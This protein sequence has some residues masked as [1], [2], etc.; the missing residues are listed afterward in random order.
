MTQTTCH[1]SLT[2]F[3]LFTF[4]FTPVSSAVTPSQ[5]KLHFF[6]TKIRPLL[7]KHCYK[8]H[9]KT[10]EKIKGN[11]TLDTKMGWTMGGDMGPAIKPGDPNRSLILKAVSYKDPDLQMPPKKKL[12]NRAIQLLRKWIADG[13]IDPRAG[14]PHVTSNN[15]DIPAAKKTW[16]YTTPKSQPLPKTQNTNW[17]KNRIDHFILAKLES[18]S[19]RPSQPAS[20]T[21]LIRRLYFDLIGLPPTTQQLNQALNDQSPTWIQTLTNKLLATKAYG[22]RWA[23]FWLDLARYAEDQAHIVGSNSSLFYPNA[24]LYRDWV[25]NALNADTP[26]NRFIQLQLAADIIQPDDLKSHV[27]LGFM[28]LGPKYYRRNAPDVMA[29]EWEDRVDTLS[30]GLLGLTV[31]CA[32]C[33]DH[34]YDPIS[35][36]DYY[37]LAGVF[38]STQMYNRKLNAQGNTKSPKDALHII[39]EGKPRDLNVLIRG[40]VQNKGPIVKRRFLE[41]LSNPTSKPFTKGSGRLELA[42]AITSPQ[43]PL[44]ARVI[45]NRIWATYFHQGIVA[46]PSNFGSLGKKPSH[47]QL[48]DDLAARFIKNGWSLKWL[49]R[50]ITSSAT[51]RQSSTPSTAAYT[52]DPANTLLSHVPRRRMSVEQWRDNILLLAGRLDIN[53]TGKSIDPRDPK[54]TKRTVYAKVSRL[55]LNPMLVTFDFPDPNAHAATRVQTVTPLQKLFV[56]NSPFIIAQARALADLTAKQPDNTPAKIDWLYTRLFS[57]KPTPPEKQL[58]TQYLQNTSGQNADRWLKYTQALLA[59]N[60]LFFID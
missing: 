46:T 57:R 30:R 12:S 7:T 17:P 27:A 19:L 56:L 6:E 21:T 49:H 33:H 1:F 51:Y 55:K 15:L 32:R 52:K 36:K 31:A 2:T 14:K 41:V 22:Q 34:K 39:R 26:Y 42:Q 4:L 47:P 54:Q 24:Y 38:A 25:I 20:K 35:T 11:L 44:T 59:S 9:A 43:N 3:I 50:Q 29:D 23:R 45:V 53:A 18:A 60:E 37:A 16:T 48:L 40:N 5:A 28:G 10:S 8:C 58:A 13:A